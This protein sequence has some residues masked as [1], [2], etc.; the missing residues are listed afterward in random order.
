MPTLRVSA[1]SIRGGIA[2]LERTGHFC[3]ALPRKNGR[4]GKANANAKPQR[5][6]ASL[7]EVD[8]VID[9]VVLQNGSRRRPQVRLN[10]MGPGIQ[11][12]APGDRA[13]HIAIVRR[14]RAYERAIG[15]APV[16]GDAQ[17]PGVIRVIN[18]ANSPRLARPRACTEPS[19]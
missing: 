10:S 1:P 14:H 2:S 6:P 17:G 9:M 13:C 3:F 19:I 12:E 18:A 5:H 15:E 8:P 7:R 11:A 4:R 16:D